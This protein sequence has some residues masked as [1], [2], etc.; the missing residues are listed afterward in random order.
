MPEQGKK[1]RK[2]KIYGRVADTAKKMRTQT[3]EAG[4]NCKCLI[5]KF[6]TNIS[7]SE[8]K[9]IVFDLTV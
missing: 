8:Q 2:R 3:L 1:L 9:Q 7:E 6:Y 4:E 5:F